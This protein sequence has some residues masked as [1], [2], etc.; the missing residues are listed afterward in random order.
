MR[1]NWWVDISACHGIGLREGE[2]KLLLSFF[3]VFLFL[4]Q[5]LVVDFQPQ[6]KKK[7]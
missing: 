3:F 5:G 7:S 4:T 2:R 1:S 6:S